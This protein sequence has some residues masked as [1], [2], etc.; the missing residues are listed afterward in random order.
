MFAQ[1]GDVPFE[2]LDSFASLEETHAAQFA[3]HD[4]L[5]G[6][7]RLQAMG[8]ALTEL[9]FSLKLHWKLGDVDAA[10]HGLVAAKE[11]QQAVSLVYGSGRF[12]GW[13]VIERLSAR[14]LQMDKHGRT[15][16]REIDV[17]LKEFVGDP[18]NP[19]PAPAVVSGGQNP[20]LAMLPESVQTALN[21]I[22]EKIG[23]AV[24]IYRSVEDD[25]GAMQN[26]I[27][28]AREIKNDPAGVLNLVG[29][30]LGVAGGVGGWFDAGANALEAAAESLGN[31]AA[32]AQ[33]LTAWVA[34]RK[35]KA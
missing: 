5:A 25:I 23:T 34:G 16:A 17:E 15:A 35:D 9:R 24:K 29:D 30:V 20:L 6:R 3:Q 26:L 21:P 22:A 19:L 32:A 11:A 8:N 2:L 27:Q 13:F 28:T 7:A 18:N 1:L 10:Y 33:S 14:T 4:V 12:V 31:G